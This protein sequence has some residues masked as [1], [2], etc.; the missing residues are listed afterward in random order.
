MTGRRL[1]VSLGAFV[2]PAVLLLPSI[3]ILAPTVT[4]A[5]AQTTVGASALPPADHTDLVAIFDP[6]V[7]RF[8]LRVTRASLMNA[9]EQRS[10]S[11]THLAIYVEPTGTYTTQD[12]IDGAV[13]VTRVFLPYVFTRWKGLLTFDVCQEPP[14]AVDNSL[15]PPPETQVYANR[16]GTKR[17][18]WPKVDVAA[19]VRRSNKEVVAAGSREDAGFSLYFAPHI[20]DTPEYQH[21]VGVTPVDLTTPPTTHDYG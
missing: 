11:G 13:N 15:S 3:A 21:S 8:G 5:A 1:L 9:K 7:R 18:A 12:Y 4:S 19:L 17:I 10:K 14:P 16:A 20:Q 2:A 6:K